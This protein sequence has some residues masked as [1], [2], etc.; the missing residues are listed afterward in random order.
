MLLI[1]NNRIHYEAPADR[2]PDNLERAIRYRLARARMAHLDATSLPSGWLQVQ[3]L[4]GGHQ[5]RPGFD[6]DNPDYQD[7]CFAILMG[8]YKLPYHTMDADELE[9]ILEII[10]AVEES[11]TDLH[12]VPNR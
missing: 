7:H 6:P 11:Y 2:T 3:A 1:V 10:L 5:V 9:K 8:L 4:T 12:R